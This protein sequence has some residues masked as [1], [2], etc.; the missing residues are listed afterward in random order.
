[1]RYLV[2]LLVLSVISCN[3]KKD[4]LVVAVS[5]QKSYE[6]VV[7]ERNAKGLGYNN[8]TF[9]D[10]FQRVDSERK[11]EVGKMIDKIECFENEG[12]GNNLQ[13]DFMKIRLSDNTY[14]TIERHIPRGANQ[15]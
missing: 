3:S 11:K 2:P 6:L 12:A 15:Q 4:E 10:V 7:F 5:L 13:S 9:W 1:M 8:I 14:F